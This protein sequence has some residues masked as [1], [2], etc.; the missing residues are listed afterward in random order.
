[1]HLGIILRLAVAALARL[2]MRA[3]DLLRGEEL[4]AVERD[5]DMPV[6]AAEEAQAPAFLKQFERPVEKRKQM[7][8]RN[9]IEHVTDVIVGGDA[10]HAEERFTIRAPAAAFEGSLVGKKGR[11]LGEEDR[12]CGHADV[13]HAMAD[14]LPRALVGKGLAACAQGIYE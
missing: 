4:R 12:K 13:A 10:L 14:V 8:G 3:A 7:I 9:R 11:A 1:M 6:K 2:A 5:Q